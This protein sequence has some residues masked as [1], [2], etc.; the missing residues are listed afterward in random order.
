M[1]ITDTAVSLTV[2]DTGTSAAFLRRHFG[3]TEQMSA[4]GFVSLA[5]PG[6]GVNVV[7]LRRGLEVLPEE[8]RH[9]TADGVVLAFVVEDIAAE[10]R[11]LREEGVAITLPL[12]EEPW[13]EKL[14]QVTDPNGVVVELVEWVKQ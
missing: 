12:R 13:G 14:F 4:D 3:Y 6:G 1:Q 11:R 9:R 10:E 2:E 5:H 8:Q 7:Y